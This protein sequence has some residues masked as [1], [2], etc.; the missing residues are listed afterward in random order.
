[1]RCVFSSFDQQHS[2]SLAGRPLQ[3]H[4]YSREG[5]DGCYWRGT[6]ASLNCIYI[7]WLTATIP[8]DWKSAV[9]IYCNLK[10]KC[11]N[12]NVATCLSYKLV[13]ILKRTVIT[14]IVVKQSLLSLL[15]LLLV[16]GADWWHPSLF[17]RVLLFRGS[18]LIGSWGHKNGHL[19]VIV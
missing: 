5:E 14:P 19:P 7:A 18:L 12:G 13:Q 17:F 10:P 1:M 3:S 11:T 2:L 6:G 4:P 8:H 15:Y 16:P 9:W